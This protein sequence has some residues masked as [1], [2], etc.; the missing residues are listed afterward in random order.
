MT[1]KH[2][3][4]LNSEETQIKAKMRHHFTLIRLEKIKFANTS[5][6]QGCVKART[7]RLQVGV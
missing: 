7:H 3:K 6:C 5:C 4:M 2:E 1:N